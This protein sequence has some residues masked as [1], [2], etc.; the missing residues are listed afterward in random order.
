MF[1]F[2]YYLDI[3]TEAQYDSFVDAIKRQFPDQIESIANHV[4]WAKQNLKKADRITWYLK[5]LRVFLSNEMTPAITGTYQFSSMEQLQQDLLHFYGYNDAAIENY[6]FS[7]QTISN[8]IQDLS[9]LEQQFQKK[10]NAEKGVAQ[11]EGDYKLFEFSDGSAWWYVNRAFCDEE[12]RSGKHCGNVVG[13]HKQDQRILSLRNSQNQVILTFILEPENTLGEMK[14]KGNRKPDER[15]HPHI[16]KLLLWDRII[17]ISGEGY[18]AEANFSIFDLN[19]KNLSI[20]YQNKSKLISDQ[21]SVNPQ[22]IL[23]APKFIQDQYKD[24][25]V[26]KMPGLN[27]LIDNGMDI[28]AWEQ[29]VRATPQLLIYLPEQLYQSYPNFERKVIDVIAS[30]SDGKILLKTPSRLSKN[31]EFLKKLLYRNAELIQAIVPTVRNY[32]ELAAIAFEE[33]PDVFMFIDDSAKTKEMCWD[34]VEFSYDNLGVV[35]TTIESYE[36][37]A[38][39]TLRE[40]PTMMSAIPEESQTLQMVLLALRGSVTFISGVRKDLVDAISEK[41]F[42][43]AIARKLHVNY[44]HLPEFIKDKYPNLLNFAV[45][46]GLTLKYVHSIHINVKEIIAIILH[47]P[48]EVE[49]LD[50]VMSHKTPEEKEFVYDT[51]R[52]NNIN[53]NQSLSESVRIF[54]LTKHLLRN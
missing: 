27:H 43:D 8:L 35:P 29:A 42:K 26:S 31:P 17:G 15:Y 6:Q 48:T 13:K 4:N 47:D 45:G 46:L 18:L 38:L 49:Y 2:R 34:A 21:I 40:H 11:Q 28:G 41:Q 51:L 50:R 33:N 52:K 39:N 5:I 16:M 3:L 1:D 53:F 9:I 7:R 25:A 44:F 12:G 10:Q 54:N 36:Q 23:T 22:E 32:K 19:E 30:D 14:A 20:V 24:I 37:L